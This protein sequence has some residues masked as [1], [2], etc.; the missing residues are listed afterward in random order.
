MV[1]KEKP[2]PLRERPRLATSG[3]AVGR[4]DTTGL[5]GNGY[6]RVNGAPHKKIA[7]P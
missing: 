7:P 2:R 5:P 6:R 3:D 4:A 1:G